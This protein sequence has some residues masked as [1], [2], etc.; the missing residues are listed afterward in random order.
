MY[1]YPNYSLR[2]YNP[3]QVFSTFRIRV[4]LLL[5]PYNWQIVNLKRPKIFQIL[6]SIPIIV[7]KVTVVE[8]HSWFD[9]SFGNVR[10]VQTVTSFVG[11]AT[12]LDM[13][14]VSVKHDGFG[15]ES[16]IVSYRSELGSVSSTCRHL[17]SVQKF[18][19]IIFYGLHQI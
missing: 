18:P 8:A 19:R 15:E 7:V 13:T 9:P 6:R 14:R 3:R 11:Q 2:I 4:R 12:V 17:L 5:I 1:S 10:A 16:S